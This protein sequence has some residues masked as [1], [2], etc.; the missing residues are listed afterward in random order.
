M[1]QVN[2]QEAKTHLSRLLQRVEAGETI[3]LARGGRAI[4]RLEPVAHPGDR[5]LGFVEGSLPDLFFFDPL[6]G[7]E[8]DAWNS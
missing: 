2:V 1:D 8:L 5:E 7:D 4:A 6:P 3:L